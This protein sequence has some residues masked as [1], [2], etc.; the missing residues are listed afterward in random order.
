[1]TPSDKK[2]EQMEFEKEFKLD[3]M[4]DSQALPSELDIDIKSLSSSEK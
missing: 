3:G 2:S 4:S 1:M